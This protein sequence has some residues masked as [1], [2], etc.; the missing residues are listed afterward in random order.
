MNK[1]IILMKVTSR[2]RYEKLKTCVTKYLTYANDAN[3]M[4]WLFTIDE[5]DETFKYEDFRMFLEVLGIKKFCI[6]T[7]NSNSKIHAVNRDIAFLE[8]NWDILLSISDDQ[9]PTLFG[10]DDI[11][12]DAM[13]DSLDYSLWFSDGHQDEINTQEILGVNYYKKQGYVYYPEYKSFFCDNEAT[14]VAEKSGKFF[15]S[16]LTI[17]KHFH[18]VWGANEFAENDALYQRNDTF[19]EHDQNLFNQRKNDGKI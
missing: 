2:G 4:F 11:I 19:W 12:R 5:D 6:P 7:G 9:I 3:N 8:A 18:P 16:P 17:I 13:P 14:I 15:K 1:K 10:Y